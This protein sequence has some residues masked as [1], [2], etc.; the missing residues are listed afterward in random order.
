MIQPNLP[1]PARRWLFQAG[2]M[3]ILAYCGLLSIMLLGELI[4][5]LQTWDRH[6]LSMVVMTVAM[7]WTGVLA[8]VFF[9]DFWRFVENAIGDD[10]RPK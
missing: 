2:R 7:L 5:L 1:R 4:T 9:P 10:A 8:H 6:S 3:I